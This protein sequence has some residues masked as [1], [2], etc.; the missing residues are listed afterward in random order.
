MIRPSDIGRPFVLLQKDLDSGKVVKKTFRGVTEYWCYGDVKENTGIMDSTG[1][2][3][4]KSTGIALKCI[5]VSKNDRLNQMK[6]P[7]VGNRPELQGKIIVTEGVH[8]FK[9]DQKDINEYLSRTGRG[10]VDNAYVD[11]TKVQ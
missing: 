8:G 10:R 1:R 5:I 9:V 6:V 11:K 2:Y 7:Y 3:I 4:E